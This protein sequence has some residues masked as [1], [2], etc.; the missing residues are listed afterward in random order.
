LWCS[1]AIS[2]Q[3]QTESFPCPRILKCFFLPWPLQDM[4]SYA[5]KHGRHPETGGSIITP[6]NYI[7]I[8]SLNRLSR[9]IHFDTPPINRL[10]HSM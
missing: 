5:G 9:P 8:R 3:H 7:Y 4:W 1:S 10:V 2:H 6:S